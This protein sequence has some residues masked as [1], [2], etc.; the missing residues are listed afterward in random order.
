LL[1]IFLVALGCLDVAGSSSCLVPRG[2]SPGPFGAQGNAGGSEGRG[3]SNSAQGVSA[4]QLPG[5]FKEGGEPASAVVKATGGPPQRSFFAWV[6]RSTLCCFGG[7][8]SDGLSSHKLWEQLDKQDELQRLRLALSTLSEV[9]AEKQ[10]MEGEDQSKADMFEIKGIDSGGEHFPE[11]ISLA[12]IQA[13]FDTF[14][15]QRQRLHVDSFKNILSK[16]EPVLSELPNVV[17]IPSNETVTVVGDLHG[18]LSDLDRIFQLRGWPAKDNVFIFNG[19][20]VD[21]GDKGV[22]V[23]ATLFALKIA[24]P[25]YV[26]LNRGNH[27]DEH[28]GR[29]YG[30]FDEVMSKYGS[31]SLY[32]RIQDVFA[33]LPLCT[34]IKDVAFVVHAGIS[35]LRGTTVSHIGAVERAKLRT[36]VKVATDAK[37]G[38][39]WKPSS[40]SLYLLEDL[41]WSDPSH[42]VLEPGS[43]RNLSPNNSRGAGTKFG[44]AMTKEWLKKNGLTTLVR[45]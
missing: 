17:T 43:E 6:L 9:A 44:S 25:D 15:T 33:L 8:L 38:G 22:E 5:S 11:E 31:I 40:R 10:M 21:R 41:L 28:I 45:P 27:E 16:V 36:T 14:H 35:R 30:F 20:F 7:F 34:I 42:P 19:D 32:D 37:S 29:A 39:G 13:M 2:G 24:L 3:P 26:H 1:A 4:G 18:S 23:V 12:S